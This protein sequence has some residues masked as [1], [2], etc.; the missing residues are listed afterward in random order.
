MLHTYFVSHVVDTLFTML[1]LTVNNNN[2]V[3]LSD[4][5][6]RFLLTGRGSNPVKIV[7]HQYMV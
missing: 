1:V 3:W 4:L 2:D 7:F 6:R 5:V